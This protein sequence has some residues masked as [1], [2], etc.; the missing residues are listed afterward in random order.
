LA[1]VMSQ[2][3]FGDKQ[4][5]ILSLSE[6]RKERLVRHLGRPLVESFTVCLTTSMVTLL[7]FSQIVPAGP[8]INLFAIPVFTWVVVFLGGASLIVFSLLGIA[9][10]LE[11]AALLTENFYYI[12][13]WVAE[14]LKDTLLGPVRLEGSSLV[15]A[16]ILLGMILVGIAVSRRGRGEARNSREIVALER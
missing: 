5:G 10:P 2:R 12:L 8:L 6:L 15:A 14:G 11:L 4:E 7:W 13:K 16:E 3:V 1:S 9:L